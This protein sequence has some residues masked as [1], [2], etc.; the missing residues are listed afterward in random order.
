MPSFRREKDMLGECEV[1]AGALYGVHTQRAIENFPVARRPVH[2]R[3]IHAYGAVKLAA[4]RTTCELRCWDEAKAAAI[5]A[6]CHLTGER[7]GETFNVV[8]NSAGDET[9]GIGQY[10]GEVLISSRRKS[11]RGD[12]AHLSTRSWKVSLNW[13]LPGHSN[14]GCRIARPTMPAWKGRRGRGSRC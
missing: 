6:A 14:G 1:P 8:Y 4:A 13:F 5:Q 12:W 11:S 10:L 3:L 9:S 2:C 7:N